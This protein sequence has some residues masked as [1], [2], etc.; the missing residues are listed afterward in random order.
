MSRA[1]G[2]WLLAYKDYTEEQ[3]APDSYHLWTGLSIIASA[4][5]RNVWLDQGVFILYPNLYVILVAPAGRIGKSTVIRMGRQILQTVP[6]IYMGPDSV[7]REELIRVM[8]KANK[9]QNDCA[10]T[11]HSTELSSLIDQSGLK[12]IQFLTD[13]YDCDYKNPKGWQYATKGSGRDNIVNPVMNLLAGT[14]PNWVS[15][16]MPV[17]ATTH[18]FTS[19]TVFVFEDKPRFAN[20][21]PKAPNESI[22]KDLELDL[23]IISALDGEFKWTKEGRKYYKEI[24]SEWQAT[25]PRDYRIEGYHWRKRTHV[26]K[27]AMLLSVAENDKLVLDYNDIK[28]AEDLLTMVEQNM[29]KTFAGVGKYELASDLNRIY[30]EILREGKMTLE[31]ITDRYHMV[32]DSETIF[33]IV[34]TLKHMGR[35]DIEGTGMNR[36]VVLRKGRSE[37]LGE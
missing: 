7:T 2:N 9:N 32:G 35:V 26:L 34:M 20:P 36:V 23:G 6:D 27:L 12:M 28:A 5:R 11:I 13:I 30:N 8:A 10:V 16:S 17:E 29:P 18:G 1:C 19:R 21:F 3:E 22:V 25:P 4:V 37:I 24:Y 15:D 33:K 14:I 31:D